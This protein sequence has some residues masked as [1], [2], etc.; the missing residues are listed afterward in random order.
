MA[1]DSRT[2]RG[3]ALSKALAVLD[4]VLSQKRPVGLPDIA[5]Q[6]GLPR[7]T[8][9][10]VLQQL[11][12]NGLLQRDPLRDRFLVGAGMTRL[13][14]SALDAAAHC[15]ASHPVL[16]AL[17]EEVGETC[18]IGVLDGREVVYIDRVECDWPLRVQ[19]Q[20]GSRLPMHCTAIGKLL[21]AHM[22][23][24]SSR[25]L[26]A[27][28]PLSRHTENT[29]TDP[30][31][32]EGQLAEIRRQGYSTS[33]EEYAIGMIAVAVPVRDENGKPVAALALQAPGAR[34]TL[35]AA[36]AYLP[37]L[38]EAAG[39]LAEAWAEPTTDDSAAA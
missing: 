11:E 15:G 21:L 28:A 7:Q 24:A 20:A 39:K 33:N 18:N 32:L 25:R 37:K 12:E 35:E 36:T 16:Q 22:N 17:V 6:L 5:A 38:E 3:S 29:I 4:S 23:R 8:V 30:Q 31:A 14:L 9:H 2:G 10:R 13:A 1:K 27:A 34:L 26:I 19:L